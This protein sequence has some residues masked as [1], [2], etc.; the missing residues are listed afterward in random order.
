[1][2][3]ITATLFPKSIALPP[4]ISCEREG[5]IRRNF[6]AKEAKQRN[7]PRANDL[8]MPQFLVQEKNRAL[9]LQAIHDGHDT[10]PKLEDHT[11]KTL[12]TVW[13][14]IHVLE[15]DGKISV[16]KT[17]KPWRFLVTK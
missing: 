11:G 4:E 8:P 2:N 10:A 15:D 7:A 6:C 17:E 9:I 5:N 1:M 14:H 13:A 3:L 12:N 16:D